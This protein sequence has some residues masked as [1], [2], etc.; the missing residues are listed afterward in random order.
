MPGNKNIDLLRKQV[1]WYIGGE[2]IPWSAELQNLNFLPLEVVSRYRDPQLKVGENY[3][4]LASNICKFWSWNMHD[5]IY[6]WGYIV[7]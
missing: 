1:R 7:L 4:Y 2:V 5:E 6:F 3:S